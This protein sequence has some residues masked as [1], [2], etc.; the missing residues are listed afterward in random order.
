MP[1]LPEAEIHR[2]RLTGWLAGR[3]IVS[4]EAPDA[5]IRRG[6]SEAALKEAAEG[7]VVEAVRRRGKFLRIE[8][9]G[10]RPDLL[11]HLGMTGKWIRRSAGEADPPAVRAV[12]RTRDDR[13]LFSDPRRLG[14]FAVC[15]PADEARLARLGPEPLG[16]AFTGARLAAMLRATHRP[17]KALLMDQDRIAGI[18][19]IQATES[20]WRAGIHPAQPGDTLVGAEATRLHRAI[21]ETLRR[22]IREARDI[23]LRYVSEGG[24]GRDAA[25][26]RFAVYGQAGEPCPRCR[27]GRIERTV[28]TGRSSFLCRRC[29]P[30]ARTGSSPPSA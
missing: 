1:E 17:V 8:L 19:N 29:Q 3:R 30:P 14:R 25:R 4:V 13:I 23:E 20:L 10:G 27:A 2:E 24:P 9:D 5:L 15:L 22:T 6:Q 21:R 11:S 12:L 18:G 28:I 26:A 7:A 16:R